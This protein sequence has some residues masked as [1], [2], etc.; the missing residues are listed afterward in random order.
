MSK[1][2]A[3]FGSGEY[4]FVARLDKLINEVSSTEQTVV[5]DP[6]TC[7]AINGVL[8]LS[9]DWERVSGESFYI[10]NDKAA[11][12]TFSTFFSSAGTRTGIYRCKVTDSTPGTPRVTYP[13]SNVEIT[14]SYD[15]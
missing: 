6:I 3:F 2:I 11:T 10:V 13:L 12:T 8:P 15:P 7:S 9:F 4:G 5:S 14:L 1:A